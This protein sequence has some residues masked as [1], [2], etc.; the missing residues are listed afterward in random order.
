M[1]EGTG[2]GSQE[3]EQTEKVLNKL[4]SKHSHEILNVNKV[5]LSYFVIDPLIFGVNWKIAHCFYPLDL[6]NR[7]LP[8][9]M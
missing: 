8:C 1:V 2:I 3:K 6:V 9:T 7:R 5:R 4:M